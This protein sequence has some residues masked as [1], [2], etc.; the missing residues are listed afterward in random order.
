MRVKSCAK[1]S[2]DF[3]REDG[4]FSS[5]QRPIKTDSADY[6]MSHRGFRD[7]PKACPGRMVLRLPHHVQPLPQHQTTAPDQGL[8]NPCLAPGGTFLHPPLDTVC[9]ASM[10]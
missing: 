4:K 10:A 3:N 2:E 9:A 5:R 7:E 6:K 8:S 1:D